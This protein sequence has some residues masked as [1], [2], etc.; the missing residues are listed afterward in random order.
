MEDPKALLQ[1]NDDHIDDSMRLA[2]SRLSI[3]DAER[4]AVSRIRNRQ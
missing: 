3:Q 2:E 4:P 1:K